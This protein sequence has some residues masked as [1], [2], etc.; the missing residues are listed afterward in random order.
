MMKCNKY[1]YIILLSLL[2]IKIFSQTPLT[3]VEIK[4]PQSYAF[5]KYGNIPVNLYT[6]A[7]DLKVPI[8][9]I[10]GEGL[11]IS[12]DLVYDSSGFIPHKKADAAGMGW[13]LI[14]GGRI[15]RNLKGTPD[16]YV[17]NNGVNG[18]PPQQNQFGE[19]KNLHGF[20]KGVKSN[21]I[22]NNV[23][24]YNVNSGGI[25]NSDGLYWWL[26]SYPNQYE[27]EPDEFI[28]NAMGL[29]GKF[30]VGNNGDVL[31]ESNDPN[32]KVDLSEMA[33]YGGSM[34]CVPPPSKITIIDGKGTKY[35]FGGDLSKYEISYSYSIIP[36]Y[37]NE[38]YLAY[39]VINSFSLAKV[40]YANGKEVN[41][42][43][44]TGYVNDNYW[45][46]LHNWSTLKFNSNIFSM[47]SYS[48]DG[49]I[50]SNLNYCLG[51]SSIANCMSN[52]STQ[53][54]SVDTFVLL[55]KSVL[56]SIKYEDNEIKISYLDTGYP[57]KHYPDSFDPEKAFN[58]FVI[59]NIETYHKNILVQNIQL[60][61][62]HLGGTFKRPFLKS[63]KNLNSNQVYSFEYNKTNDLPPYYTKGL[64]HWGYWNSN[65]SNT[66]LAPFD[67]Y[68]FSTG[69][70][71]L[72]NTFRDANIQ[73]YDIALINKVTY[74]TKGFSIFEYEPH[75]YSRRIER[76]SAS[77]FLPT[78]TNNNGVAGGSR[79]KKISSYASSGELS[80][81]KEYR[82]VNSLTSTMSSG[83][84]MNWPRYFY[85]IT[86]TI[87]SGNSSY[88]NTWMLKSSSNVQKNSLDSYNVG[89]GKVFE[90]ET[91]KGY[92]QHEF[93]SYETYPDLIS[94]D[95]YNL[96]QYKGGTYTPINLYKNF[97]NLYG[98]DKSILRGKPLS[99]K[100]FSQNDSVNPIK[101]V[102][103]EYHDN[104]EFNPNNSKDN[105][106]YISIQHTSGVWVQ[107]YRRFM[108][109]SNMKKKIIKDYFNG[110]E[111][112]SETEYF[113][114]SPN[115]LNVSR[116]KSTLATNEV[117]ENKFQYL[118]DLS[119]GIPPIFKQMM[120]LKNMTGIPMNISKY[121]NNLKI[122][123][124]QT[125]YAPIDA[126]PEELST[127]YL[128]KIFYSKTNGDLDISSISQDKKYTID[129]YDNKSNVIQYTPESGIPVA[130]V[131]GYNGT[132]PIAK[133]EGATYAQIQS[134]ATAIMTASDTD[135]SA[136]PNN[137][138]AD[139]LNVLKTFRA[140][141][142]NYHVTTYTYDPLIG[143]RSITP[144]SG[145][146]EVY[147][148]D[149]ANRLMEIREQ[150]K[151]GKLL[152]EFKYNYK[153]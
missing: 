141:L 8:T 142:P 116:E 25:G 38:D 109:Y 110:V 78:L 20:L 101:T 82:Y 83:I 40:I 56:K 115:H 9:N 74:P 124:E 6:G 5:E 59:N 44:E 23:Q 97:N 111:I 121:K 87:S 143:V 105:N 84:L 99:E 72:N 113:Y 94:P 140:S 52:Y 64:D 43:Y 86:Q 42:E 28:F 69:D 33:L 93:S 2:T 73:N 131:W 134:L 77:E 81:Q 145:I 126:L 45:C 137:D 39:P 98:V 118:S 3:N 153:N 68:N 150:S 122:S 114:D 26:G 50:N 55:K 32:I 104:M 144:P 71:T 29:S 129:L 46:E 70:Y 117:L 149:T 60:S 37:P 62:D 57:I 16:E 127:R 17:G 147:L 112:K 76:T 130:I 119:T 10:G 31:V 80:S 65:N 54:S 132:Q 120:I 146:R 67:T 103:Y 21:P 63:I 125:L 89:Y 95:A 100:Y 49:G 53:N 15:T 90:I 85:S 24:A 14:A 152:K 96:R 22:T 133:I 75:L 58:E 51:S 7:I 4:S 35:I 19:Y 108:N 1:I 128:P 102:D 136:A 88:T 30:I 148:Y 135:A 138:E 36:D 106:N 34:F 11:G 27:G 91:N 139:L 79:V 107:G 18:N 92:I 12:A 47:D 48:Q 151:T 66:R 41:F 61:Y 123:E 13:S